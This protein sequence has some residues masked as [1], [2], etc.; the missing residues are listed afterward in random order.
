MVVAVA[1]VVVHVV[2]V[3]ADCRQWR[4][5]LISGVQSFSISP[6]RQSTA[7]SVVQVKV[8]AVKVV[9]WWWLTVMAKGDD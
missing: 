3:I 9:V 5:K 7:D 6:W 1:V 4:C 2:V 8:V